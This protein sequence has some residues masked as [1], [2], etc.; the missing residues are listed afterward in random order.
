[1]LKGFVFRLI[2]PLVALALL[3]PAIVPL[4][5]H[6]HP[7][8]FV[9]VLCTGTETVTIYFRPDGTPIET[10]KSDHG[11]CVLCAIDCDKPNRLATWSPAPKGVQI[12]F[13]QSSAWLSP[14]ISETLSGS[15]RGPPRF[16]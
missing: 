7:K 11:S 2:A 8:I 15:P 3:V 14:V 4:A 16:L 1:M 5:L 10:T 13:D 9:S 6:L 12:N